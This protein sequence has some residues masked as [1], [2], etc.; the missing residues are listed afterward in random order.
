MSRVHGGPCD[1]LDC[2]A[3]S[4]RQNKSSKPKQKPQQRSYKYYLMGLSLCFMA[5]T[6]TLRVTLHLSQKQSTA[7][8]TESVQAVVPTD[9]FHH[10]VSE[11]N[12]PSSSAL[13]GPNDDNDNDNGDD[14]TEQPLVRPDDFIYEFRNV[15]WDGAPIVLEDYK[16]IFFTTPKVACTTFKQLF[17]R[18]MHLPDWKSQDSNRMLPHNPKT[19]GLKYL[20]NYTLEEANSMMTSPEYTRAIFVREPKSRFLSAFLDKGMGNFGGFVQVKCCPRTRDC[21]KQAQ[22]SEGFLQLIHKCSDPHWDPQAARMEPKYWNYINFVGHFERLSQDGPALVKRIGAWDEYGTSGWGKDGNSSLFQPAAAVDQNHATGSSDKIWQWLT[23]AL[24]RKIESYYQDDYKHPLFDFRLSNLTKDVWVGAN[25][26][27]FT[28]GPWDGAPIVVEKHKLLFFSIPRLGALV[29]KQAFRR[30]EGLPNWKKAGGPKGLPHD[31]VYNGLKYLYD[32]TDEE[33]E[34]MIKDPTW[35]KAIFIRN[36]KDRFLDLYSHMSEHPKEVQKQCCPGNPGCEKQAQTLIRLLDL[37]LKCK[38]EQWEPQSRRMEA[39]YWEYVNF[40]GRMETIEEDSKRFL[41]RVGAWEEIGATGWGVNGTER[42]FAA[43]GH[44]Y[45]SVMAAMISY[46]PVV[47]RHLEE[48]YKE[49]LEKERFGFAKKPTPL[50]R[51]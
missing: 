37:S 49:D 12:E 28:R 23:P 46:T 19:N 1:E 51:K 29:W 38:S 40:I 11:S 21:V 20:W 10:L 7:Q 24:E 35:T 44:E 36:P 33:A 26:K 22:T 25:D 32:Y 48:V 3:A 42:I 8:A 45:D 43:T 2:S 17:R 41:D 16:L 6:T 18:M 39:K 47:D 5:V 31:P 34:K 14:E 30:M 13:V 4:H 9:L 50:L 15:R 27:I